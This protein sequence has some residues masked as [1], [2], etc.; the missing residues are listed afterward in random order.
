MEVTALG[1]D[2]KRNFVDSLKLPREVILDLPLLSMT[3]RE[4]IIIENF[5]GILEYSSDKI[6]INTKCGILKITGKSLVLGQV[7]SECL[8]ITGV[9]SSVEFI[10]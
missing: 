2:I 9:V 8:S 10:S 6:R 3:G 1:I 5:K 7:T 4:E